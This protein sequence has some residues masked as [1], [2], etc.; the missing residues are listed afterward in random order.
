MCAFG[1]A[2]LDTLFVTSIRLPDA[3]PHALDGAVFALQPGVCGVEESAYA[4]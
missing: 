4:L 3:Q 2:K 1:G